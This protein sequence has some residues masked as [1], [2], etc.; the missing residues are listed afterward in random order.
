MAPPAYL[1]FWLLPDMWEITEDP[2]FCED[3]F[4]TLNFI[5]TLLVDLGKK[6]KKV[7]NVTKPGISKDF[8][9]VCIHISSDHCD[10]AVKWQG[11]F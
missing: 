7:N 1:A 4:L 2:I 11:A 10:F 9:S 5:F 6:K 8:F 3:L